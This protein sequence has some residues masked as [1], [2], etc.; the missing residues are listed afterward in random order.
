MEGQTKDVMAAALAEAFG[1]IHSLL[2]IDEINT[3][4]QLQLLM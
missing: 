1:Q 3:L 2:N 4:K